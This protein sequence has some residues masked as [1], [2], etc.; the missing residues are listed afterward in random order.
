MTAVATTPAMIPV[1]QDRSR[2]TATPLLELVNNLAREQ[3]SQV[4]LPITIILEGTGKFRA[5]HSVLTGVTNTILI[6]FQSE[7]NSG[8][9]GIEHVEDILNEFSGFALARSHA[10]R[11]TTR[12]PPI[13]A[14]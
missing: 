12:S 14:V 4:S 5:K 10:S 6:P 2:T 7:A 13:D 8:H 3:G 1:N 9:A 11:V